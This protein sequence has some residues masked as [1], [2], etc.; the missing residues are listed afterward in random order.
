MRPLDRRFIIFHQ[1]KTVGDFYLVCADQIRSN[2]GKACAD[3]SSL[4]CL[5]LSSDGTS[6]T[7]F[8]SRRQLER[9]VDDIGCLILG[10]AHHG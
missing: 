4:I 10:A 6:A 2:D 3:G 9:S 1:H 7:F 8:L 5:S